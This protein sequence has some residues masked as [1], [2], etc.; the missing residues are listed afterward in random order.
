MA[1]R[2]APSKPH[3]AHDLCPRKQVS[4][5]CAEQACLSFATSRTTTPGSTKPFKPDLEMAITW[6][7]SSLLATWSHLLSVLGYVRVQRSLI[8]DYLI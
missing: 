1:R 5:R 2:R 6:E 7:A 3:G 4:S 8:W